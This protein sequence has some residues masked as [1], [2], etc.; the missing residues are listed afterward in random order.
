MC[1]RYTLICIDDLGT[2]FRIVDPTLGFRSHFNVAPSAKMPVIVSRE[3][4]EA[5][6]M[7]WGLFSDLMK[8]VKGGFRVLSTRERRHWWIT[9]C[10]VPCWEQTGVLSPQPVF[11][12]GNKREKTVPFYIRLKADSVFA[13]A[14]PYNVCNDAEGSPLSTF[15]IITTRANELVAPL[16]DRMPVILKRG[17]EDHWLLGGPSLQEELDKILAPIQTGK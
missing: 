9:R 10:L 5:V 8:N 17:D 3:R 12:N 13:F 15:T 2:L 14:G 16:H 6:I 11:M 1:G 7:H 4:T